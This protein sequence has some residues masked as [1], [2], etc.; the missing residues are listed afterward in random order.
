MLSLKKY[1]IILLLLTLSTLTAKEQ[2][3]VTIEAPYIVVQDTAQ[4][5]I[6]QVKFLT[7]SVHEWPRHTYINYSVSVRDNMN[8]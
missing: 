6:S 7:F 2:P 5:H 1:L 4:Y 8:Q 3:K